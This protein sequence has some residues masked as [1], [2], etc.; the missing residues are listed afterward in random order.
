MEVKKLRILITEFF[1]T[2]NDSNPVFVNDIFHYYQNKSHQHNL[3][4]NTSR[5]GNNSLFVLGAHI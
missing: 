3:H 5:Y 1:K 2:L 4:S